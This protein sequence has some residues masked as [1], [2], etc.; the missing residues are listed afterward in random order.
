MAL[1]KINSAIEKY[2]RAKW[3]KRLFMIPKK[4]ALPIIQTPPKRSSSVPVHMQPKDD[5]QIQNPLLQQQQ[6]QPAL[7]NQFVLTDDQKIDQLVKLGFTDRAMN[8][9]ALRR[10]GGNV[11]IAA[12][13]LTETRAN[14][15]MS[16]SNLFST[17]NMPPASLPTS[18]PLYASHAHSLGNTLPMQSAVS[19]NNAQVNPFTSHLSSGLMPQ[20]QQQPSMFISQQQQQQQA[21]SVG[22]PPPPNTGNMFA[23][24]QISFSLQQNNGALFPVQQ[25]QQTASPFMQQPNPTTQVSANVNDPFNLA[26]N[27]FA[28]PLPNN[29]IGN[30]NAG[31]STRSVY[32]GITFTLFKGYNSTP[33]FNTINNHGQ[34]QQFSSAPN[35]PFQAPATSNPF[36]QMNT[37]Y[38]TPTATTISN[39]S[40]NNI[41]PFMN[42]SFNNNNMAT[43]PW[44]TNPS[45]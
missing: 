44:S 29:V 22:F 41:L 37:T 38:T 30:L 18:N 39:Q 40:G 25:Q 31:K 26:P 32:E 13:I 3:E 23:T 16:M 2:I 17:N 6:Q 24:Q 28:T 4:T 7:P 35:T 19:T 33:L 12:T 1:I 11:D 10:A 20:Q 9:D 21:N 42:Q 15:V 14:N 43:N 5:I 27:N 45:F 36:S 8:V 34:P